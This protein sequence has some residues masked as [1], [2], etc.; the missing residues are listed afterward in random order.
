MRLLLLGTV[1]LMLAGSEASA[2]LQAPSAG[3]SRDASEAMHSQIRIGQPTEPSPED[4]AA[5][6]VLARISIEDV[7]AIAKEAGIADAKK[8]TRKDNTDWVIGTANGVEISADPYECA[9]GSCRALTLAAYF[10]KQDSVDERFVTSWNI[11]KITKMI[12][13]PD[14]GNV[15]MI[16]TLKLYGGVTRDHIKQM[17]EIFTASIK[18]AIEFKPS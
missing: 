9:K 15:V 12:K 4:P 18:D 13:F 10:G 8:D 6:G 11:R 16:Y 1:V 14:S 3:G 2:Q 5:A 7:L 17:T